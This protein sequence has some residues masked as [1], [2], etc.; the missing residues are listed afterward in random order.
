MS[1][2]SGTRTNG[3]NTTAFGSLN[4]LDDGDIA[5]DMEM[6]AVKGPKLDLHLEPTRRV[7]SDT[8]G[9]FDLS[10]AQGK[11]G[12][13]VEGRGPRADMGVLGATTTVYADVDTNCLPS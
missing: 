7:D 8:D 12:S 13:G 3:R 9:G 6:E 1:S 2:G 4:G 10:Q 5:F 11:A